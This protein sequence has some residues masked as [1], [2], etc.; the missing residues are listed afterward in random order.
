MQA[1]LSSSPKGRGTGKA[2]SQ[3]FP[4]LESGNWGWK[5]D[6]LLYH[7]CFLFMNNVIYRMLSFGK[8]GLERITAFSQTEMSIV[9]GTGWSTKFT[10]MNVCVKWLGLPMLHDWL[11]LDPHGIS[12][13]EAIFLTLFPFLVQ[14][15]PTFKG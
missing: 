8:K 10:F 11:F 3:A 1:V 14:I 7:V 15:V 5:C 6:S 4:T 2:W 12:E 9:F 13:S